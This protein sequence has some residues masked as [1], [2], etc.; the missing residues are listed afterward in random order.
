VPSTDPTALSIVRVVGA[1]PD[2]VHDKVLGLPLTTVVGVAIKV[3]ILG[4]TALTVTVTVLVT[5]PA[6]FVAVSLYVV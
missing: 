5:V 1:P 3:S 6:V 4:I 2:N